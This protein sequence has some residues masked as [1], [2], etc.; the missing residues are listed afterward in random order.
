MIPAAARAVAGQA[1]SRFLLKSFLSLVIVAGSALAGR[2]GAALALLVIFS[3][4]TGPALRISSL[5]LSGVFDRILVSP[6]SRP[7]AALYFTG[8]WGLAVGIALVPA[9]VVAVSRSG[10][11]LIIPLVTGILLAVAAGTFAGLVSDSLAGAHFSAILVSGML[12]VAA[13]V[14]G[15][16]SPVLPFGSLVQTGSA[17]AV[18]AQLGLI[19]GVLL[20]L[21]AISTR[22]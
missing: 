20:L 10:P 12:I 3:G 21:A 7:T 8:I 15:P 19:A 2:E 13:V 17:V 6:V 14:P 5:R 22:M 4:V 16:L 11:A 18:P 9:A 1:P